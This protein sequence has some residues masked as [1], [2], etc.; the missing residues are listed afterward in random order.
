MLETRSIPKIEYKDFSF[1]LH[2]RAEQL[3]CV[4]KAQ[5]ELTYRCNLH[6][7][8]CYTD[9]YNTKE[10]FPRELSFE[11]ILRLIDEMRDIGIIWLNLTGGEI[12]MHPRFFDIYEY[13][14]YKGLLLMLYSNGTL[15]TKA[16][17]EQLKRSPPFSI[18]VSCHSIHEQ[19]FDQ[20]TQ[21]PGSFRAFMRGMELLQQSGLP[22]CFK[23]TAMK[24]NKEELPQIKQF[25]E[26]LGQKFGFTTALSPR[27]N[28]NLS[29]LDH[30]LSAE[31]VKA[32]DDERY[33]I[34]NEASCTDPSDW[35][36]S[37]SD[38]LFRCGC[39]TNTIHISA[40][41]ELGTCTL[42]YEHRVS[43]RD[44]SL[45]DAIDKVFHAVRTHRYQSDS[46]CRAC[47]VR[48]FCEKKPS[49]ARWECG[50]AEAPIPYNCDVALGR[51]ERLVGKPLLHPL[52]RTQRQETRRQ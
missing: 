24:W 1:K 14:Y 28:G 44:Y 45:K 8:H 27:L 3:D 12:F 9:P 31:E 22:F 43:L 2:E 26:S 35:L 15:F 39:A 13:A 21:V 19:T 20:F 41:G 52:R 5:L 46:P 50:S 16:I 6:C 10:F 36:S 38:R 47:H 29:P 48:R 51:A 17:V 37:S 18:D 7:V 34:A 42:Q 40:W 11:E 25:I 30:R 33:G 23:T 49:E 32:L 4:V